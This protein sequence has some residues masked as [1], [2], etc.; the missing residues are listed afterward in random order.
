MTLKTQ[1]ISLVFSFLFGVLFSILVNLNY[2]WLF[3]KCRFF[4]IIITMVFVID[5]AL[6]YFFLLKLIN[7]GVVHPYFYLMVLVGFYLSFPTTKLFRK[8]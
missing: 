2:R 1:I 5:C 4:Q 3:T 8:K 6:L 7:D